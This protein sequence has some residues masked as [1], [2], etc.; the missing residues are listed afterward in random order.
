[1]TSGRALVRALSLADAIAIVVGCVI[2]TGVFLKA[3]LM[4]Q[5]L[6]SPG[7]VLLAWLAAGLLSLAGALTYA[8]L[9]AMYPESGGEYVFLGKAYGDFPAFLYGWTQWAVASPGGIAAIAAAFAIFLGAV[10]P[11]GAPWVERTAPVF[12]QVVHWQFGL[13]QIVAV[14]VILVFTA[15]N[16]FAVIVGGRVQSVLAVAKVLGIAVI[17]VGAFAFSSSGGT[18]NLGAPA[19]QAATGVTAFGAAML[20][21]LWAYSG[22]YSLPLVAGEVE[23]PQ[24]N[25]P[26][27]LILG[28]LAVLVIYLLVNLSYFWVLPV[29]EV[30]TANSTAHRAALP[31][32]TKAA[33]TFLGPLGVKFISIAFIV[34][35]VGALNG[36]VLS[37][38]RIPFA[39]AQ[40]GMLFARLG[41]LSE[42]SRVPVTAIM[43]QGAWASV[44]AL[45][46]SFDQI[47]TCTIFSLWLFY[48]F[49]GG[50]I[51]VLRWKQPDLP[52][53]YKAF[54]YP[55]VPAVFV[56][57]AAWLV[58]NTLRTNTVESIVGLVFVASGVPVYLYFK[59]RRA[60]SV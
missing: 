57:V 30:A 13:Q 39:M 28:M 40:S 60:R 25:V 58:I 18:A 42:K 44:L 16:C 47:T 32:A 37:R 55:V 43:V 11:L 52:R 46:G 53:P 1:V 2:G 6:G 34:S 12:G 49:T 48:S 29:S 17:I 7:L 14:A 19:G 26:R 56:I 21:A 36:M 59:R 54:G 51:F 23:N 4:T 45:S 5:L 15:I 8:E 33:E 3:A 41:Q 22:W 38:A 31:V 35:A 20:A 9:G 24:R 27:G 10:I 50:A